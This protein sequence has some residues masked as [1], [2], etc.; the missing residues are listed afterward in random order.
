M[1]DSIRENY[2]WWNWGEPEKKQEGVY[3]FKKK[4]AAIDKP[5]RYFSKIKNKDLLHQTSNI[6]LKEYPGFFVVSFNELGDKNEKN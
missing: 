5:Y 2:Q 1:C 4:W 3:K 6:L